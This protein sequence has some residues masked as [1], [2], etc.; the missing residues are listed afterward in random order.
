MFKLFIINLLFLSIVNCDD[1]K[2]TTSSK[3]TPTYSLNQ[4]YNSTDLKQLS[5]TVFITQALNFIFTGQY[6]GNV[7]IGDDYD[8]NS[9]DKLLDGALFFISSQFESANP[10]QD[11]SG[12]QTA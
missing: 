7:T 9:L 4:Y 10:D 8:E 5:N 11:I 1:S 12:R 2:N 6:D 3:P